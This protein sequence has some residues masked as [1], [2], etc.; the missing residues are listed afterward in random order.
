[1][2]TVGF[3]VGVVLVA[4]SLFAVLQP[5]LQ[6]SKRL[7]A[8]SLI[9]ERQHDHLLRFYEQCIASIRDL[10]EDHAMG[11]L[12]TAEYET[13]REQ[14]VQRA[15]RVLKALHEIKKHQV[16][17]EVDEQLATDD[18]SLDQLLEDAIASYAG[19]KA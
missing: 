3:I 11:K 15:E 16:L 2:S 13:E 1:M 17:V 12:I 19:A 6:R 5:L 14:W 8:Q 18:A 4:V 10:E 7:D 9:I